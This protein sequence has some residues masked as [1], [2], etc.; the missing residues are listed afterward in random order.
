[1][2]RK[3]ARELISSI[4]QG[5]LAAAK[6]LITALLPAMKGG[7]WDTL[8]T[9]HKVIYLVAIAIK[10]GER[11]GRNDKEPAAITGNHTAGLET[12]PFKKEAE[13]TAVY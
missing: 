8:P 12:M 13:E 9:S 4:N 2:D 3:E 1:M 10:Y 7:K 6:A 5:T 11:R